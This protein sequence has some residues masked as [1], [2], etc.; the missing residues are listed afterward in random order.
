MIEGDCK[1]GWAFAAVISNNGS[2]YQ[3]EMNH[4]IF[5]HD[6]TTVIFTFVIYKELRTI[7]KTVM[8]KFID[9]VNNSNKEV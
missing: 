4:F 5:P 3:S 2:S 7:F 8:L 9:D 6:K 1:I